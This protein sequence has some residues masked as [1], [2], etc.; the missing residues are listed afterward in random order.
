MDEGL[1]LVWDMD[2]TLIGNGVESSYLLFNPKA[3]NILKR[4]LNLRPARVR[5]IFL[6]TNNS[7]DELIK[8]FHRKLS[9]NLRVPFVFDQIMTAT[10]PDRLPTKPDFGPPK[11]LED[12]ITLLR[13]DKAEFDPAT[14]ANRIYFFDDVQDHAIRSELPEDHYI[15]ITPPF[16][17][18]TTDDTNY[19]PIYQA[20]GMTG[21]YKKKLKLKPKK[22]VGKT[23]KWRRSPKSIKEK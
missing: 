2:Q 13:R 5:A 22:K 10:D 15:Q 20:L 18:L 1:V 11:R 16:T 4:A 17:A 9:Y 3:I 21:G 7:A 14:V 19:Q 6:L 23:R 8:E 12:V